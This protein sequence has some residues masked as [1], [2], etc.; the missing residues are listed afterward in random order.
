MKQEILKIEL[1]EKELEE[2]VGGAGLTTKQKFN[3]FKLGFKKPFCMK[4]FG[5]FKHFPY[6][7]EHKDTS[8]F[9]NLGVDAARFTAVAAISAVA[10]GLYHAVPFA[11][12]KGKEL[13]GW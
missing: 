3:G 4:T 2:I 13:L 12:K 1:S 11:Y 8:K 10:I 9:L 5:S 7:E 6:S